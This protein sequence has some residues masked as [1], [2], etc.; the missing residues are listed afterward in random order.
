MDTEKIHD[1]INNFYNIR[2]DNYA[3]DI[4]EEFTQNAITDN[5]PISEYK[6]YFKEYDKNK[7]LS[8]KDKKVLLLFIKYVGLGYALSQKRINRRNRIKIYDSFQELQQTTSQ[9]LF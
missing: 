1:E 8:K 6:T 4:V 3:R 7:K 9:R 5:I 2:Q